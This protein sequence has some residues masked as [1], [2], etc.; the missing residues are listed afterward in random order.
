MPGTTT[1]GDPIAAVSCM[2]SSVRSRKSPVEPSAPAPARPSHRRPLAGAD[3]A[4][5]RTRRPHQPTRAGCV[6]ALVKDGGRVLAPHML[7]V[8]CGRGPR[9]SMRTPDPANPALDHVPMCVRDGVLSWLG[10]LWVGW[11]ARSGGKRSCGSRM[12]PGVRRPVSVAG[13]SGRHAV[14]A[15]TSSA[16]RV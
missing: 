3:Q 8:G 2:A 7:P 4:P 5:T 16:G 6:K 11:S 12:V 13:G 10:R 9:C 14:R 1:D 15:D